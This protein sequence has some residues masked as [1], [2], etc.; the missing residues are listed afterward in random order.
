MT[1]TPNHQPTTTQG[2]NSAGNLRH[3]LPGLQLL[4]NYHKEWFPKDLVAGIVLTAI[5]IPVGMSYSQAAGLPAIY[6][7]Y[8]TI[9]PMLAYA[10]FGPSRILVVGP[11][12]SL[13]GIIAATILPL[14]A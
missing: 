10:L 4:T 9:I 6:G 3:W 7:L 11:D 1:S 13:A 14:A 8:A 2:E 5:L 12:S